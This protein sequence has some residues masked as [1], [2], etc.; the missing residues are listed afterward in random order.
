MEH[1]PQLHGIL[2]G[3]IALTAIVVGLVYLVVRRVKDR[4]RSDRDPVTDRNP[5]ANDRSREP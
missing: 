5:H 3:V 2:L 1:G 4:R